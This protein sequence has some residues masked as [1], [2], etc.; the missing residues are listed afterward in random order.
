MRERRASRYD[1]AGEA[2]RQ[3]HGHQGEQDSQRVG[4]RAGDDRRSESLGGGVGVLQGLGHR[5]QGRRVGERSGEHPCQERSPATERLPDRRGCAQPEQEDP[6]R[7]TVF[8]QSAQA[9]GGKEPGP[10]RQAN[11]VDEEHQAERRDEIGKVDPGT[12][13]P[14]NSPAKSTAATPSEN[15]NSLTCPSR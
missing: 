4:D 8:A 12:T 14:T 9:E 10:A 7:E 3:R 6:E 1:A 2:L 11:G 15:P 13:Q 5:R